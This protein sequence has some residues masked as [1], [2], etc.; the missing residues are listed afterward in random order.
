MRNRSHGP[1]LGSG[2][3]CAQ[4]ESAT[5]IRPGATIIRAPNGAER[6]RNHMAVT[7]TAIRKMPPPPVASP[8]TFISGGPKVGYG[9]RPRPP[10]VSALPFETES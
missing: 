6:S 4:P 7:V 1:A 2:C 9:G 10:T 5:T 8:F 3:G